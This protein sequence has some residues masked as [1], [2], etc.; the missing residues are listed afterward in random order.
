MAHPITPERRKQLAEKHGINEQYLYQCLTGRRDMGPAE[1]MRLETET[2]KELTRQ[3]LCQKTYISIWPDLSKPSATEATELQPPV[4]VTT[5]PVLAADMAHLEQEGIL[6]LPKPA[7]PVEA[8]DGNERRKVVRRDDD[9]I[10]NAK[11]AAYEAK[12]AGQGA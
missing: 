7:K 1:A 4:I 8:W 11:L 10:K 2:G 9:T 3:M 6:K 5:D 12:E